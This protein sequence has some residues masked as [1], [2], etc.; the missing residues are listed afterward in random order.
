MTIEV[1]TT[2]PLV[3]LHRS[4]TMTPLRQRML[5]DMG[6]RNLAVNTQLAYVRIQPLPTSAATG[7]LRPQGSPENTLVSS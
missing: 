4:L 2:A 7:R 1:L 6:I 5:Q 3:P